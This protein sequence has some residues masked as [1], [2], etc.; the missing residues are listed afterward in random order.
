MRG[1]HL[2]SSVTPSRYCDHL[3][4]VPLSPQKGTI[5]PPIKTSFGECN[6]DARKGSRPPLEVSGMAMKALDLHRQDGTAQ[7]GWYNAV[8]RKAVLAVRDTCVG[9]SMSSQEP[10]P[11]CMWPQ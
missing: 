10:S 5:P 7:T 2:C 6:N 3:G 9:C 8:L 1:T 11:T 4:G